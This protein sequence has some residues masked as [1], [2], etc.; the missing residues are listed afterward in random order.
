MENEVID[1]IAI[2]YADRLSAKG[3]DITEEMIEKNINGLKILLEKYL[4]SKNTLKPLP[5]LLSGDEIMQILEIKPSPELGQ[6]VNLLK[7]A[8]ISSEVTTKEE[9]VNFVK[10]IKKTS[11]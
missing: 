10:N 3:P 2:A 5:K 1:L 8:Q 11:L 4:A 9:A 7:E 6:I